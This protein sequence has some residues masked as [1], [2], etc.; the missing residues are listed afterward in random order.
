MDECEQLRLQILLRQRKQNER[1]AKAG[2]PLLNKT[3]KKKK[4]STKLPL[5]E[6]GLIEDSAMEFDDW[7]AIGY[8]EGRKGS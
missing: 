1:R 5:P 3:P 8:S 4:P 2:K 7:V 6:S